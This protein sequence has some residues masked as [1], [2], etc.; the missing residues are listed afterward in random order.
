MYQQLAE[1]AG[2][3]VLPLEKLQDPHAAIGN[4]VHIFGIG[5]ALLATL[6]STKF[7]PPPLPPPLGMPPD[8]E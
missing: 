8:Q 2:V 3:D 1:T 5:V 4:S 6:L 7:D